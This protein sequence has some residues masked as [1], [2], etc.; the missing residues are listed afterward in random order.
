V[1]SIATDK[2]YGYEETDYQYEKV[3]IGKY[4][5]GSDVGR[6]AAREGPEEEEGE[7]E[8][9]RQGGR[10]AVAGDVVGRVEL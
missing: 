5:P 2:R 1:P 8:R 6:A 9:D 4:L 7:D 10:Y 3:E